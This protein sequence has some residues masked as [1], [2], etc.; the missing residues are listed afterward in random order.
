MKKSYSVCYPWQGEEGQYRLHFGRRLSTDCKP[1]PSNIFSYS[2]RLH[3][4]RLCCR[5]MGRSSFFWDS[6]RGSR[7]IRRHITR[8]PR[9][10]CSR[11]GV[12]WKEAPA[13]IGICTR[14][15]YGSLIISLL[16]GIGAAASVK[17]SILNRGY[18][19]CENAG[20]YKRLLRINVYV[21]DIDTCHRLTLQKENRARAGLR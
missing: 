8:S 6:R 15:F 9:T 19:I 2:D 13:A 3:S 18:F 1:S 16:I 21:R 10:W 14:I 5:R 20:T 12:P 11:K 17:Q 7:E 4:I